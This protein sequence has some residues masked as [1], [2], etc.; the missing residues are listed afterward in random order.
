MNR[1]QKKCLVASSGLHGFAVLLLVFGSAFFVAKEKPL[2]QS[3]LQFVPS[4]F[5]EDALAGGGGNPNVARTDD[6]QKGVETAPVRPPAPPTPAPEPEPI[7]PPPPKPAPTKPEKVTPPKPEPI[8]AALKPVETAKPKPV[9][10][11][12]PVKPR[13]DLSELKPIDRTATDKRKAQKEAEAQEAARQQAAANA[14]RQKLAQQIGNA[15]AAMQR[16]FQK[17]TK[18]DVGGP[19]GEAYANYGALVQ[20]VYEDAWNIP[21]ELDDDDVAVEVKV[22]IARDGR[23]LSARVTRRSGKASMDRSVQRALD[24]VKLIG[25]PFPAFIKDAERSFTIEFNLKA[26]PLLG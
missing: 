20:A 6:V 25:Q 12:L 17:G 19:G 5:V 16:G 22:T 18:V 23:V 13:I 14:A 1:L 24:A 9:D 8:K 10:K 4:R 3:K 21:V 15:T 11:P 2:T 7:Q 26:K